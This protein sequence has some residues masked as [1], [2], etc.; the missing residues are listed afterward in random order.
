MRV[1]LPRDP[2]QWMALV[3]SIGCVALAPRLFAKHPR[4]ERLL[5]G[6]A[7][8]VA[9]TLSGLYVL[10]Y[11]R[12]GPRIIDA[13][14]YWL[15][16]RALASG[17]LSFPVGEPAA[18]VLGRFL[19]RS[20]DGSAA[21]IFPPGYPAV[22]A[23]AMIARAPLA[24]G[25][26][27]AFGIVLATASLTS[28]TTRALDGSVAR[29]AGL[30]AALLSMSCAA[31]R[32]HT[33]DT[34]SHGLSALCI[35][36]GVASLFALDE[37]PPKRRRWLCVSMGLSLG[38]LIA[39]RPVSG[40]ALGVTL[41]VGVL[42]T[43]LANRRGAIALAALGLVPGLA[44][45]FAH[46]RAATG[47]FG[48]SSQSL[49]YGLSDGPPGCFRYGF[50]DSIG[51][52]GEHGDFV[53]AALP[54]GFGFTAVAGTT[55]RRLW[56]HLVDPL[57]A[58]PLALLVPLG[59]WIGR[60]D[61][62][63]QLLALGVGLQIAAYVPFYFDGNYPG[64]G[65]RFYADVLPL[66][67]ALAALAIVTVSHRASSASARRMA[68]I[69]ALPW[70]GFSVRAGFDHGLLRDREG[71]APMFDASRVT[72][73]GVTRGLVFVETDHGFN[74]GHD[75][76][77]TSDVEVLRLHRDGLDR[78]AWEARGKPPAFFYRYDASDRGAS[79]TLEPLSL[80]KASL[81]IEGE[82]LWPAMNQH[83]AWA[84]PEYASGTCAS[85]G[86]W[87]RLHRASASSP[88]SIEVALPAQL[89][90]GHSI[91][92]RMVSDSV[93]A[94]VDVHLD[95][96]L[97]PLRLRELTDEPCRQLEPVDVPLGTQALSLTLHVPSH[98]NVFALDTIRIRRN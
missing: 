25:P 49:Y 37:A 4:R 91:A 75:P 96:R 80:E 56:M 16:A 78:L 24:V 74:L 63:V 52:L 71:G 18:S 70:V 93:E 73:A 45:L 1:G 14:S 38:W 30:V 29:D 48:L 17:L 10:V 5:V 43:P 81:D 72:G 40:A 19:V 57:N 83:N 13:T 85:K 50:G 28:R 42:R 32:Y 39:T 84:L 82:S 92:P 59:A 34:M 53:R 86:R 95:G 60:R 46:Q 8:S 69:I 54:S 27:L 87:L 47:A 7:A 58:E 76:A 9:A 31:L 23:L 94:S 64:G 11:L 61:A 90:G 21:V 77:R 89:L 6:I 26:V 51:C 68:A 15:E 36:L 22:L 41:T 35:G 2:A 44:L 12:G 98:G 88:A 65:A 33:A 67:H 62:R 97:V 66:E 55:L 3:V 79:P 20:P